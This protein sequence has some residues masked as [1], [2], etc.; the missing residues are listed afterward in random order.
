[1]KLYKEYKAVITKIN[2]VSVISALSYSSMVVQGLMMLLL[3]TKVP[4]WVS[5]DTLY[6]SKFDLCKILKSSLLSK[7]VSLVKSRLRKGV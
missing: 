6:Q 7:T 1:M 3:T 2:Y 5:G 4:G